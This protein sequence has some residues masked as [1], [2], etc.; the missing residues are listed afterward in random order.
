MPQTEAGADPEGAIRLFENR[1]RRTLN[2]QFLTEV[3][4]C[5]F[6]KAVDTSRFCAHP[7]SAFTVLNNGLYVVPAQSIFWPVTIKS[8]KF[9]IPGAAHPASSC[10][11]PYRSRGILVNHGNGHPRQSL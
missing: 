10:A 9:L 7:Q 2:P 8:V 6:F 4:Q 3:A 1:T 5:S 11:Y